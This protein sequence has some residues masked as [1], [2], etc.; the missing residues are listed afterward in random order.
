MVQL[1]VLFINQIR[2]KVINIKSRSAFN[3]NPCHIGDIIKAVF[4]TQHKRKKNENDEWV[5]SEEQ[6]DI[7]KNY[8]II[9]KF[10]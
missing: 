9:K 4:N 10:E 8:A 5:Q 6:E 1:F 2:E 7:L 3:N